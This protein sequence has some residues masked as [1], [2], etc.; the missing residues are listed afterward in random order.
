MEML[1]IIVVV[2]VVAWYLG[3]LK[4]GRKAVDSSTV[5][6]NLTL[7]KWVQDSARSFKV[8]PVT[9][10]QMD[11]LIESTSRADQIRDLLR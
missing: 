3:L 11:A 10:E 2:V 9:T 5:V 4:L 1:F 7:D 8:E 6:A